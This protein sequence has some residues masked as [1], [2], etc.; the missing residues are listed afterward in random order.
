MRR[1]S[2]ARALAAAM[3]SHTMCQMEAGT[4]WRCVEEGGAEKGCAME[5]DLRDSVLKSTWVVKKKLAKHAVA[6]FI[7]RQHFGSYLL[8]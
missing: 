3:R 5:K 8:I 4:S 2:T 6:L 7:F 1:E